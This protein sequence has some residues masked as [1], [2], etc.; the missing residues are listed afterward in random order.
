MEQRLGKAAKDALIAETGVRV[1]RKAPAQEVYWHVDICA[2][3]ARLMDVLGDLGPGDRRI[4]EA[5]CREGTLRAAARALAPEQPYYRAFVQ[6][7][8]KAYR[9]ALTR[10]T[11][12]P[13]LGT[14]FARLALL[15]SVE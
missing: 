3:I 8:V 6:R 7:K 15:R 4:I 5:V 12:D 9:K 14:L 13:E 11:A 2:L 10:L 1:R